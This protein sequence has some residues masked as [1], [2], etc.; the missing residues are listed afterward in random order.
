MPLPVCETPELLLEVEAATLLIRWRVA[1]CGRRIEA[2]HVDRG[3]RCRIILEPDIIPIVGTIPSDAPT[4]CER[5]ILAAIRAAGR[6]LLTPEI[7]IALEDRHG[8]STVGRT[9]ARMVRDGRLTNVNRRGYGIAEKEE[10]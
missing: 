3:V 10:A 4:E 5:A 6:R 9:L 1:A 8:E 7:V 2:E